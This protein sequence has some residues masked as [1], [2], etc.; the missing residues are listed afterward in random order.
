MKILL[1][2]D[3]HENL[4]ALEAILRRDGLECVKARSGEEA[5]ELLL[6]SDFALALLDV[7]MPGMDGF[8]LAEYM[9]GS[10]RS[11]HIPI[12]FLTALSKE[13]RHV[14]RGYEVGAVDS[15][16]DI[17][18]TAALLDELALL[19]PDSRIICSRIAAGSGT[20]S[21]AHGQLPVPVP[22]VLNVLAGSELCLDFSGLTGERTTPTGVAP[23]RTRNSC[24]RFPC[25]NMR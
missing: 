8:Q 2:D 1:V 6:V 10:E 9:R 18:G 24:T 13:D 23:T 17:V 5:L 16:A 20:V 25:S 12:I 15:I 14:F 19:G 7:Q 4:L 21:C 22:A 3:L 11:R